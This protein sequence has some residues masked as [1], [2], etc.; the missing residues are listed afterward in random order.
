M[1]ASEQRQLLCAMTIPQAKCKLWHKERGPRATGTKVSSIIALINK[2]EPDMH[3][4][5]LDLFK[6]S[7]TGRSKKEITKAINVFL[8]VVA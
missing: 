5:L 3:E 1:L 6:E 4:R 8:D 7:P 2:N